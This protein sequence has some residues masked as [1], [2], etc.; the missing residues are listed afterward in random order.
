MKRSVREYL[1]L[2]RKETVALDR[3]FNNYEAIKFTEQ[4]FFVV[5]KR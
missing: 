4:Q 3:T 5:E 1:S 2:K